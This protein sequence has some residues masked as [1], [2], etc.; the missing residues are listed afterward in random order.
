M[1]ASP[2]L[3]W[4]ALLLAGLLE[5]VWAIGFKFAFRSNHLATAVTVAALWGSFGLLL[6]AVRS[7]PI[8]TAYA[9]W[10]GIG[11][12]GAAIVGMVWLKEP[13]TAARILSIALIIAGIVG[14]RL[15]HHP[16]G[17]A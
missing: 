4:S 13:A 10:T 9:V 15:G 7:L 12:A 6:F 1:N 8:G 16:S 2:A 14:L 5:I 3:A 11:A 17:P